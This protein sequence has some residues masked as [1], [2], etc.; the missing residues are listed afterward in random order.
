MCEWGVWGRKI[1]IINDD[2]H[3]QKVI[4]LKYLLN[5][6]WT[7]LNYT[8]NISG[9]PYDIITLVTCPIAGLGQRSQEG[10]RY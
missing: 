2:F 10:K 9:D 7:Q 6:T 5:G 8:F 3:Y 1:L 4:I